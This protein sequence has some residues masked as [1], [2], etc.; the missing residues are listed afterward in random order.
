M[1]GSACTGGRGSILRPVTISPSTRRAQSISTYRRSR[2]GS[3]RVSH[4]NTETCPVPSASSAPSMT[5][6]LNRPKLSVVISPTVNERPASSACASVFGAKP[7]RSA[8]RM[9]R[10]IVSA[11]SL[12][13]PLSAFDAVP[14]DTP[15]DSAT[16]LMVARRALRSWPSSGRPGGAAVPSPLVPDLPTQRRS[17]VDVPEPRL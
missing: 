5:G 12:P 8:A 15:A 10:S 2:S 17:A 7:S 14:T 11:R 9:T 1:P 6:M 4:M 13:C 16:S 3:S